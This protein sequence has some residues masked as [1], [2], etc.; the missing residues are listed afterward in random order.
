MFDY[1]A[2]I[3]GPEGDF[4]CING[5]FRSQDF[6]LPLPRRKRNIQPNGPLP[7]VSEGATGFSSNGT[8]FITQSFD[9][10]IDAKFTTICADSL[11]INTASLICSANGFGHGFPYPLFGSRD[12]FSLTFT[13]DVVNISCPSYSQSLDNCTITIDEYLTCSSYLVSCVQGKFSD[14]PLYFLYIYSM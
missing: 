12:D 1:A 7:P 2:D 11:D 9:I 6:G 10:C 3:F 14:T 5:T 13:R 4:P 8:P